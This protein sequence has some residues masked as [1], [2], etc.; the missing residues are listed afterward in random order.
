MNILIDPQLTIEEKLATINLEIDYILMELYD[1][2]QANDQK[3]V[4]HHKRRL[5]RLVD[6]KNTINT[7]KSRNLSHCK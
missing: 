7:Y 6:R 1:A 2:L 4:R 5:R 3:T